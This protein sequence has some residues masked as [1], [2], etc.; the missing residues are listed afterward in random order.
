MDLRIQRTKN[1]IKDAF[2]ELRTKKPIEKITVTE[3]TKLASINKATFYLHYSD[4][5]ALS[6][7]IEN[8]LID[9]ILFDIEVQE[10]FFDDPQKHAN[11]IFTAILAHR[12]QL[13][14]VFSGSRNSQFS[15]KI[16]DRIKAMLFKACPDYYSTKND[17]ILSFLIQGIFHT[18]KTSRMTG[19][20]TEKYDELSKLCSLVIMQTEQPQK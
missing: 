14:Y 18:V 1:A 11:E 20:M 2:L 12:E 19:D 9:D 10:K 5:Y 3:L 17:V 13:D 15:D 6:D 16:E 8:S 7:E 4:I